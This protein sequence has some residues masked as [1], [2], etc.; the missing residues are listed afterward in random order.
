M[1]TI[2]HILAGGVIAYAVKDKYGRAGAGAVLAATVAP[3]LDMVLMLGDQITYLQYH[4]VV[5]NSL[6]GVIAITLIVTLAAYRLGRGKAAVGALLAL[7][8]AGVGLHVLMDLANSYG[9]KLLWPFTD[10]WYALDMVFIV[11]PLLTGLLVLS[12]IIMRFG[13]DRTGVLVGCFLLLFSYW[14]VRYYEHGKAVDRFRAEYPKAAKISAFPSALDPFSWHMVA[15][16]EDWFRLGWYNIKLGRWSGNE[17]IAKEMGNDG[18]KAALASDAGRVFV[19]FARHP[20]IS[21][22]ELPNG[23]LVNIQDLRFA[24]RPGDQNFV[25]TQQVDK[26]G[27]VTKS[28]FEF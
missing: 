11:D 3:D 2:T 6:L 16:D 4:R 24:L 15:E 17:A 5:G 14:G 8:F 27:K 28:E 19:E 22:E 1:D 25:L 21:Y 12:L 18:I 10:K 20:Y 26:G 23:W 9:C 13:A 7:S